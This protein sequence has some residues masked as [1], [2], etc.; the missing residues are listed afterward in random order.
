MITRFSKNPVMQIIGIVRWNY[1]TIL[2]FAICAVAAY[3]ICI[4]YNHTAFKLPAV[5]VSILGGALA[6]FLGFRNS[7][8][9]DRWWEA[10]KIWGAVVNDSR[11]LGLETITYPIAKIEEDEKEIKAW[12]TRVLHR[13][14]AWLY[15][16]K[17]HLRKQ[18]ADLSK[19]LSEEEIESVSS[20]NNIPA[21]L[22]ILQGNDM[23]K[24]FKKGWID[25]FRFTAISGTLKK[26]YDDQGK[27]ERI[28]N[29]VFPFYYNYFTL[30][31]LWLFTLGLPFAMAEIMPNWGLIP[32]SILISFAFFIL[33]K[34]GIITENPFRD[35]AADTPISTITR[36]IEIDLLQMLDSNDVPEGMPVVKGKFG[37]MYQ[38]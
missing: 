8:A 34:S 19:Y 23:Q 22:I 20:K 28:K 2:Y 17:G 37:V 21:Q 1:L 15:A 11:S 25:E 18:P 16:L 7:S 35:S 27:A 14:I 36:G 29:T 12:K 3:V 4:Q 9:Y 24:A 32:V 10:R 13:H 5:P 38:K 26:F 31:F 33:N 6:I 30:F